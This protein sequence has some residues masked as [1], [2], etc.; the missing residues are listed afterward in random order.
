MF[1]NRVTALV[2][3]CSLADVLRRNLLLTL[4]EAGSFRLRWSRR[5]LDETEEA[6][7]RIMVGKGEDA[8]AAHASRARDAMERAFEEAMVEGCDALLGT[9][10]DLPD[11]GDLHVVA[12]A[13]KAQAAVIVT[14]N[15][16][17]FPSDLLKPL[18]LE[19]VPADIF[20]ADT[21]ALAPGRAVAAVRSMRMR[22]RKPEL[23]AADLLTRMEGR[24]LTEAAGLLR[25][26][27][28]SL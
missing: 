2:D 16:K 4:A 7:R 25:S 21:I 22:F 6:I 18:A 27:R 17:H 14:E 5:I 3:A 19:A 20:I 10:L 26:F 23:S 24:G 15:I 9:S 12:A 11:A 8:A 28:E 13:V 1:S